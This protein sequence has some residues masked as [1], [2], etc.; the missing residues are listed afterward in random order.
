M[1]QLFEPAFAV[2]LFCYMM[3]KLVK[4]ILKFFNCYNCYN[5]VWDLY[6]GIIFFYFFEFVN[7]FIKKFFYFAKNGFI[8]FY[9]FHVTLFFCT[10]NCLLSAV[11]NLFIFFFIIKYFDIIRKLSLN[12]EGIKYFFF[13][14]WIKYNNLFYPFLEADSSW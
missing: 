1:G 7:S 10:R 9:I 5:W 13:N 4:Q 3:L 12:G 2:L 14:Y 11:I 6:L 8:S